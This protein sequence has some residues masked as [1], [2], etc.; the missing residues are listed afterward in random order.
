MADSTYQRPAAEAP[1]T[2]DL[3]FGSVLSRKRRLR[4]LNRDGTFNISRRKLDWWRS[5]TSYH[6]M[7]NLSNTRFI[8]LLVTGYLL[9]N[10]IFSLGYLACGPEALVGD[11]HVNAFAKAFFFSVD[12]FATIGYGNVVPLGLAA[13]LLVTLE[14]MVGLLSFALATGI[15]FARFSRPVAEIIFSRDA[16]IAPYR[17]MTAFEFRII[18]GRE[19]QLIELQ[20]KIVFSRFEEIDGT[21]QR[22]YYQLALE[23]S[24]VA[25]FPLSWTIVHPIDDKSPLKGWTQ[26]QL[27][28]ANAEFLVLLTGIDETFAQTVHSRS[29][30]VAEELI[31]G[32]RWVKLFEADEQPILYLDMERFHRHEQAPIT[33]ALGALSQ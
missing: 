32:A 15:M 5:L 17:G 2:N 8:A 1:D 25:F 22:R 11:A 29:S 20:A 18:N 28:D 23:R 21:R 26:Q 7:L 9:I 14:A 6:T 10:L 30:Y 3:G 13:N 4:L 16:I 19:N 27:T 12:T 24:S 31:W 33:D